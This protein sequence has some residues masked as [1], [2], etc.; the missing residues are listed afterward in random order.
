MRTL[1]KILGALGLLLLL[2]S[3]FT[4][5]FVTGQGTLSAAKAAVGA[6]LI[7]IFFATNFKQLG[8]FASGKSTFFFVSSAVMGVLLLGS[9]VAVNYIAA[10]RT[11]TW[12]LTHKKIHSLAPQTLSTLAGLKE[13]VKVVAF[14]EANHPA[15]DAWEAMLQRYQREA[16]EKFE[17]T[18]KDP[19]K[20]PDLAKKYEVKAGQMTV[21]LTRG[22]GEKES[23]T[24]VAYPAEQELTNALIK[25]SQVGEQ[26]VYFLSGHGEWPLEATSREEAATSLTELKKELVQE[27]YQP[28]PLNLAGKAELPK[29]AALL[30]VAGARMPLGDGEVKAVRKYLDEGGRLLFFSEPDTSP[31]Q[32]MEKLLAEYG[33][34]LDHGVM[35]DDRLATNSPYIFLTA[36]QFYAD[37]E[38]TRVLKAAQLNL[39]FRTAR[40]L[41]VLRDGL[42][43]GVKAD[44]IV[45]SSPYAWEESTPDDHP[46]P[47]SGE[48]TGSIPLVVTSTRATA[49]AANKRFDEARVVAFG[50]SEMLVNALFGYEANRNLILN[51]LGWASNQISKI[52]IRPPDRDIST[53]DIDKDMMGRIRFV[54]T[55][56]FPLSLL[57]I[58]LAIWFTRRS[59]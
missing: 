53:L 42:A 27:G 47:T 37:H 26:K 41:T 57:G 35:A 28:E 50:D 45:M 23:H 15:Y 24:A 46:S 18:F 32:E 6:V 40:G 21:V 9:L 39:L 44:P 5:F 33:I 20:N 34:Q 31:G 56:L 2:T 25:L 17:Y 13:K 38:M 48:K 14:L 49:S 52:T 3:P 8:Q 22:E 59:K 19:A 12:D 4:Y 7:A 36:P 58:G 43:S 1:G 11:K 51:A 55:D 10:K 54:S 29:D 30:V 16:P